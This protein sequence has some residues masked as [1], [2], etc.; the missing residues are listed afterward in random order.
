MAGAGVGLGLAILAAVAAG[1]AAAFDAA[2]LARFVETGRCPG[3]DLSGADFAN[4][5][6]PATEAFHADLRGADLRGARLEGTV[7]TGA[8]FAGAD[9][10]GAALD[11]ADLGDA[12]F[13][14]ADLSNA[15]GAFARFDGADFA[16]ARMVGFDACYDQSFARASFRGADLQGAF[17]CAG[18]WTDATLDG[19]DFRAADLTLGFGLTQEQLNTACGDAATKLEGL[20]IPTCP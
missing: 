13:R 20:V 19:A 4:I 18:D 14:G 3:C 11:T 1:P 7:L 10:R 15:T 17:L 5:A 6:R 2:D 16:G 12:I 8:D 9:L